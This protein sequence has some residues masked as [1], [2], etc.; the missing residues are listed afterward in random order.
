VTTSVDAAA[1][2]HRL[3]VERLDLAGRVEVADL[4][5]RLDVAPE[6]IRRD[7]RLLERQRRLER[8]HGGAVRRA[9]RPLSPFDGTTPQLPAR[10]AQ[11]AELV[12]EQLPSRGTIFVGASPLTAAVAEALSRRPPAAATLTV[13]T[14]SVDVAVIVSRVESL[15]VYNVGGRVDASDRGQHGDWALTE[16]ERFRMDLA[17]LPASGLTVDGGVF[18]PSPLTAATTS[19]AVRA[20]SAIWLLLEPESFG[21]AGVVHAA[22]ADVVDQVFVPVAP[23]EQQLKPFRD[24]AIPVITCGDPA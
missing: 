16:I 19:A 12:V 8:V 1:D 4:A 18:A 9:E 11:L 21:R 7:L 5:A 17:L 14:T 20:S 13:V 6:T 24:A 10:Y 2:R 23:H 22:N 3:I 15:Q